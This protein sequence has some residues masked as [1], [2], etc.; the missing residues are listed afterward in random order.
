MIWLYISAACVVLR[1]KSH[2]LHLS[3]A[4]S[5]WAIHFRPTSY[6][7]GRRAA[8]VLNFLVWEVSRWCRAVYL[9]DLGI[10]WLWQLSV[11]AGERCSLARFRWISALYPDYDVEYL[12]LCREHLRLPS[13]SCH[14]RYGLATPIHYGTAHWLFLLVKSDVWPY[15][16]LHLLAHAQ[17]FV[18][19]FGG[20]AQWQETYLHYHRNS[21][22]WVVQGEHQLLRQPVATLSLGFQ[23][24]HVKTHLFQADWCFLEPL[25][26]SQKAHTRISAVAILIFSRDAPLAVFW[27]KYLVL[28]D[29][30]RIDT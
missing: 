16:E 27:R 26:W 3:V 1:Q 21:Q 19:Y 30:E 2:Q 29:F 23:N 28:C 18:L 5:S 22:E 9:V 20:D 7:G 15:L 25:S 13:P 10:S 6:A 8:L 11:V 24:I 4:I 14:W 12:F 17:I